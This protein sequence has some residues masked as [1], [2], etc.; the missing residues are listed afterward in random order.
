MIF[1][2]F[3]FTLCVAVTSNEVRALWHHFKAISCG[4]DKID[5]E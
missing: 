3:A 4:N 1:I 5:R 2:T